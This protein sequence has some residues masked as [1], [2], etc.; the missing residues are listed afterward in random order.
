MQVYALPLWFMQFC[1]VF[2][3][4]RSSELHKIK[5]LQ[6]LHGTAKKPQKFG[7]PLNKTPSFY[8]SDLI[9]FE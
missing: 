2:V 3:T 1:V 9:N 5:E 4:L 6:E 8:M 7:T